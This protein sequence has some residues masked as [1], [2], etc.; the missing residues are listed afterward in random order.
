MSMKS[1]VIPM[2][3]FTAAGMLSACSTSPTGR[4]QLKLYSSAQ[5]A[6]MGT[7]AFDAMKVE[8]K[9]SVKAINNKFVSCVADSISQYVPESVFSGKWELV[10]FDDPQVNAFALPG[11]KIGVYTGL[12]EVTENQHQLAA[13]IGHE[14]GHVIAEHGNERMSSSTLIGVG[15]DVTNQL[16]QTNQ[17][18]NNNLIMAAIGVGVQVGVQLPFSRTHETEADLIGLDLMAKAGFKPEESVKLWENMS[19]ASGGERQAEFLS[20]HPSPQSRIKKLRQ[21]MAPASAL[22][23]KTK[24]KPSC[25]KI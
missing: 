15:M 18:A 1:F 14:I 2:L 11:G 20:T 4:H 24:N 10:V 17:I 22:Y 6:S 16:L 12:L 13:V 7:Q 8:Q 3:V 23:A 5:L 21:N 9:V 19:A 25:S